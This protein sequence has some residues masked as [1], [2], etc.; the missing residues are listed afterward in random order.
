MTD[1]VL[2]WIIGTGITILSA[3]VCHLYT[4]LTAMRNQM[5]DVYSKQETTQMIG[6]FMR[7][8]TEAIEEMKRAIDKLSDTTSRLDRALEVSIV[9]IRRLN[10]EIE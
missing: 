6:L 10:R 4:Q 5:Q 3:I 9:E 7:P 2:L 1:Q 8:L